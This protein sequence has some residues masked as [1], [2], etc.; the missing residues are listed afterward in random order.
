MEYEHAGSVNWKWHVLLHNE[1][2]LP[3]ASTIHPMFGENL[4]YGMSTLRYLLRARHFSKS[5]T[6][7]SP[8]NRQGFLTSSQVKIGPRMLLLL[9]RCINFD[10]ILNPS[11]NI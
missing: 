1:N 8:C 9:L 5:S 10:P 2:D 6:K 7:S 3:D 4:A 11:E